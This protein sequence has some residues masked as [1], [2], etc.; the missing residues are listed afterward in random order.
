MKPHVTSL[1]TPHGYMDIE[2]AD[3]YLIVSMAHKPVPLLGKITIRADKDQKLIGPNI[4]MRGNQA[5]C[6]S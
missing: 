6:P 5:Q 4:P 3:I 2:H 1:S